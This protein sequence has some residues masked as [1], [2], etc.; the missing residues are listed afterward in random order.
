MACGTPVVTSRVNG[1]QEIAGEAAL[2]VNPGDAGQI[3]DAIMRVLSEAELRAALSA[4]GLER[5]NQFTWDRCARQT[6][7]LLNGLAPRDRL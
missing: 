1:L 5:A 6:L 3:A 2:F 4:R 7:D